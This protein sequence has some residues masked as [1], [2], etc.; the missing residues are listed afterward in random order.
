[1]LSGGLGPPGRRVV[2]ALPLHRPWGAAPVATSTS[3]WLC[4]AAW[5][6]QIFPDILLHPWPAGPFV[7]SPQ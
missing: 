1:M 6:Q 4:Q 7:N 2:Q 5:G 3:L